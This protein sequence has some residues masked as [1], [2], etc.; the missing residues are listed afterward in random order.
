M[1]LISVKVTGSDQTVSGMGSDSGHVDI[2]FWRV[3]STGLNVSKL[4]ESSGSSLPMVHPRF[5]Q[6]FQGIVIGSLG[7]ESGCLG[8][9]HASSPK[10]G[11]R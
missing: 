11:E 3:L 9:G 1:E 7:C 2:G 4:H 6:K 10:G 5:G 8:S